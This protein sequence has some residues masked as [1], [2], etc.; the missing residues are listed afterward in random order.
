MSKKSKKKKAPMSF[1]TKIIFLVLLCVACYSGYKVFT[2]LNTYF[3]GSHTYSAIRAEI[4]TDDEKGPVDFDK[5]KKIN[6]DI[7][8]WLKCPDTVIDYPVCQA[9]DNYYYLY[10]LADRT[11]NGC[12]SL[13]VNFS[14]NPNFKDSNTIIYGHHMADGSMFN[15]LTKYES[16]E[17]YDAHPIMHLYTPKKTYRVEIFSG[18]VTPGDSDSYTIGFSDDASYCDWLTDITGKSDF[19][20]DVKVKASDRIVTLSTCTTALDE[21]RYVLHGKLV[22]EKKGEYR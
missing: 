12:G 10:R 21:T 3:T 11:E 19:V 18:Y 22:E 7:V 4:D 6:K 8:A 9:E 15:I 20:S 16:Q 13:F 5:L 14:N 2:A 1:T 17:F